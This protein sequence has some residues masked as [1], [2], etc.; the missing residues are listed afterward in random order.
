M[1]RAG[2]VRNGTSKKRNGRRIRPRNANA[3]LNGFQAVER[4]LCNFFGL[5]DF[6]AADDALSRTLTTG[7]ARNWRFLAGVSATFFAGVDLAVGFA[8]ALAVL[9]ALD[10]FD[11]VL[12]TV[13]LTPAIICN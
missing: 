7:A 12:A 2:R 11:F 6:C 1:A 9:L 10:V 4:A 5:P 3:A 8:L 13:H